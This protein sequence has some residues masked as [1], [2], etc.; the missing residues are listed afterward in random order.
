MSKLSVVC[1]DIDNMSID[2][3]LKNVTSTDD[4]V[5]VEKR[6]SAIIAMYKLLEFNL[7]PDL[8]L[9]LLDESE[10]QLALA[11]AGGG[12]TTQMNIK[13]IAEKMFRKS[14]LHE[15]K[16][17][18]N[19]MLCLVY[20]RHN[21]NDVKARHSELVY[22]LKRFG[23]T[24]IDD[25]LNVMT[26][27][28]FCGIWIEQ[29]KG[30]C[31]IVGFTQMSD[32]D[33]KSQMSAAV[34]VM[35][36][37]FNLDISENDIKI[38]DLVQ[39]YNIM[40]ESML[41]YDEITSL[42]KFIDI[43]QDIEFI[44]AV[45][46]AYDSVKARKRGYDYTDMLTIFYKMVSENSDILKVIQDNYEYVMAD[47]VQD[48][49]KL[50]MSIIKLISKDRPL[51]CIGDDDQAIY[52]FRG[53]DSNN[54]L[55]FQETFPEGKVFLL[56]T[57]RRCPSNVISLASSVIE[58]N[59]NRYGK[60]IRAINPDGDIE[61]RGYSDR[62]GQF[63]AVTEL[64]KGMTEEERSNT[65]VC[66]RNKNSSTTLA[67]M[68]LRNNIHFHVFSGVK[69]FEYG[70]Y[71]AVFDVLRA[72][73]SGNN[74]NLLFNLYKCLPITKNDM[75]V[76]LKYDPKKRE[77][78]DGSLLTTIDKIDFGKFINNQ[79][80]NKNLKY[81]I[82]ISKNIGT[83]PLNKY[84]AVIIQMVK[85]YHWNWMVEMLQLDI[86]EDNA[87]TEQIVKYFN[88]N[89]T[90]AEKLTEYEAEVRLLNADD[91]NMNGVCLSTFHSL[92]GLEFDNVIMIDMQESIFPN[93]T[94]IDMKP[95]DEQSKMELKECET[96]LCYV[97][98]TRAKKKL[99]M[100][101]SKVDPSIFI[102]LSLANAEKLKET[103][104]TET[105]VKSSSF[106]NEVEQPKEE[107]ETDEDEIIID[108]DEEDNNLNL[109]RIKIQ[110]DDGESITLED[111]KNSDEKDKVSEQANRFKTNLNFRDQLRGR[112]FK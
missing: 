52:Q 35:I 99:V 100:F 78:T 107:I 56:K 12:K 72:L 91:R 39:L 7:E 112:F 61:F 6:K 40:R 38:S 80:F 76:A 64:L 106:L 17:K 50:M 26:I 22:R 88:V 86:D 60:E 25:S 32:E 36:K 77:G 68:L 14:R 102:S 90:F 51:V 47:E 19:N 3:I 94:Y 67:E 34:R 79:S 30:R 84:A 85:S 108:D 97:A 49:T 10:K 93:E 41:D 27:H 66:Y 46:K 103:K 54:I 33:I 8:L 55:K 73:Q 48:I 28:S 44:K 70:L 2:D 63:L 53:A 1:P 31:G 109:S 29:Y 20:N 4:V 96:R 95:Y 101:Y 42:T 5:D 92:K 105:I 75:A 71:K 65:C 87:F 13:A 57:N 43:G 69:P 37:K 59:K 110:E 81:L 16:I 15:G 9:F 83:L 21:V 62:Q 111:I 58:R 98:M 45:F 89:K 82:G 104:T 23:L 24:G 11:P 74:K 18:G